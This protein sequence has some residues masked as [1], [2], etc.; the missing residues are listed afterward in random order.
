[1]RK[2]LAI[3]LVLAVF[4][5]TFSNVVEFFEGIP[6]VVRFV[7]GGAIAVYGLSWAYTWLF[8]PIV[9]VT[10]TKY[11]AYNFGPFIVVDSYLWYEASESSRN[12]V[13]NHE[14]V[15]YVQHAVY[16]PILSISYPILALYSN[17]KS[18]NQWD[19]NYWEIQANLASDEPPS[20][21]PLV[22]W[23]W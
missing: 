13:L 21:K 4:C 20:W 14:Y 3:V 18:G 19:D 7:V 8:D 2:L 22:I 23:E 9:V 17:I 16:G 15:H 6:P 5:V 11:G 12:L 10:D 1:M